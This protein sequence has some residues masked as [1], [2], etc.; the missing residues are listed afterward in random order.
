MNPLFLL[1]STAQA[2]DILIP[3]FF[4]KDGIDSTE[5]SSYETQMVDE[6]RRLGASV[7]SPSTLEVEYPAFTNNCY[8]SQVCVERMLERAGAKMIVVSSVDMGELG[9]NISLRYYRKS[10]PAP[11]Q[12]LVEKDLSKEKMD[13]F[14]ISAGQEAN[15][16]FEMLP[17]ITEV[18][19]KVDPKVVYI[20][21]DPVKPKAPPKT[22]EDDTR[23][24]GLPKKLQDDYLN[25]PFSIEEW[26]KVQ[27][28]RANNVL[29]EIHLGV[30]FG[31][32]VRR[33][34]T[35]IGLTPQLQTYGIYEYDS[36]ISGVPGVNMGGSIGYAPTWWLETSIYGGVVLYQ[37]EL[38]TG[39]EVQ[40]QAGIVIED[41]E[42]TY[43]PTTSAVGHIEP[44]IRLY[45]APSGPVKPYILGAAFIRIF[46]GYNPPNL[47]AVEYSPRPGGVHVGATGGI[48]LA[49]DSYSPVGV[50]L[51]V[52]YTYLLNSLNYSRLDI[53]ENTPGYTIETI[54]EQLNFTNQI[55][56]FKVGMSLRFQ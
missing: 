11:V 28:I 13:G 30:S 8:T 3:H 15:V 29:V 31:D 27:R 54:P 25:S 19:P 5:L 48:G 14:W 20:N 33:Y 7:I 23:L 42:V 26:L 53:S 10:D 51:E 22:L 17:A 24:K 2:D 1:F 36:W 55:I 50:F 12:V 4:S 49:F 21:P 56:A 43:D 9:Y 34:D 40:E 37:K 16:L 32:V 39:W 6:L 45:M 18:Q 47:E 44:R 41:D 35:R 46:D 38:S 52:P